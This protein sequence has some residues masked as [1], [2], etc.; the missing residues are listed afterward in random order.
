MTEFLEEFLTDSL[1]ECLA[2]FL[3]KFLL[4]NMIKDINLQ[5]LTCTN[6]NAS[7]CVQKQKSIVFNQIRGLD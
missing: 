5:S 1:D 6:T 7:D 3:L 2:E 4:K